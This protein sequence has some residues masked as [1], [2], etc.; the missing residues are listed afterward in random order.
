MNRNRDFRDDFFLQ[1][2][3]S[4]ENGLTVEKEGNG[5]KEVILWNMIKAS[6]FVC[7]PF[8][9]RKKKLER[10]SESTDLK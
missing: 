2:L 3:L 4:S 7:A 6:K 1:T 5:I 10:K 9:G 8:E